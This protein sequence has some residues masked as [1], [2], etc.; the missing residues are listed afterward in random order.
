M[1][2]EIFQY[3]E[4][5]EGDELIPTN[6]EKKLWYYIYFDI[7]CHQPVHCFHVTSVSPEAVMDRG[8]CDAL[9][10]KVEGS[11]HH[12]RTVQ[13]VDKVGWKPISILAGVNTEARDILSFVSYFQELPIK[14]YFLINFQFLNK[15]K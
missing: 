1:L 8:E 10:P 4:L 3:R 2:R 13:G 11:Q 7:F 15:I 6:T 5:V 12:V 14:I 9:R